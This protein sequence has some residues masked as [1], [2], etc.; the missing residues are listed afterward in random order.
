MDHQPGSKRAREVEEEEEESQHELAPRL[1]HQKQKAA[2]VVLQASRAG[3]AQHPLLGMASKQTAYLLGRSKNEAYALTRQD[4]IMTTRAASVY[5]ARHSSFPGQV[6][7][8][9]ALQPGDAAQPAK[10]VTTAE[11]W[12]REVSTHSKIGHHVSYRR[13]VEVAFCRLS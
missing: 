9:K 1:K 12:L 5:T 2:T 10:T 4:H 6:I 7:V 13:S 8:V 11:L 3:Q